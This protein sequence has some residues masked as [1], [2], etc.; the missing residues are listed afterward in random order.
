MEKERKI[1]ENYSEFVGMYV[2]VE[3]M[4]EKLQTR[5][6][7]LV[8]E[9]ENWK[10]WLWEEMSDPER[11]VIKKIFKEKFGERENNSS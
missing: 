10:G 5:N 6:S 9:L 2:T 8:K 4:I 7:P 1:L 3:R 11:F